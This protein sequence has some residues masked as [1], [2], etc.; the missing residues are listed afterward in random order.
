MATNTKA[1]LLNLGIYVADNNIKRARGSWVFNIA[2]PGQNIQDE[3]FSIAASG[4]Y[5]WTPRVGNVASVLI[6]DKPLTAV[7]TTPLA[8]SYTL[9]LSQLWIV[10]YSLQT[11]AF[12]NQSTTD[13]AHLS[14]FSV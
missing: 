8:I 11:V 13:T 7:V 14:I 6:T 10:D 5:T 1:L 2:S 4:T 12:T 3:Y 9:T